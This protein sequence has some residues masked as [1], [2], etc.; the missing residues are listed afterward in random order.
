MSQLFAIPQSHLYLTK[1]MFPGVNLLNQ[2]A[3]KFVFIFYLIFSRF[4][5]CFKK[6]L[7]S[8]FLQFIFIPVLV[9]LVVKL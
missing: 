9:I 4:V 2:N 8:L 1:R 6:K 7:Y 3:Y 5:L